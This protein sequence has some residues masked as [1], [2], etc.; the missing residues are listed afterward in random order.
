MRDFIN[1]GSSPCE[2][3]CAQVGTP[4]YYERA[5]KECD[6]F[7]EL[8]RSC[9]GNEPEGSSARLIVK[10]FPHDF[11]SYWEVCCS[12]DDEDRVGMSYAYHVEGNSPATWD[13]EPNSCLWQDS[14]EGNAEE[15]V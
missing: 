12:F 14:G 8:I 7:R 6:R 15:S 13:A 2:E 1:I 5:R 3:D 4:N 11:G 10:S 9:C